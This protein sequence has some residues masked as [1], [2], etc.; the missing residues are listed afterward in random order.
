MIGIIPAAGHSTRIYG[1]PKFLLPIANSYLL[2]QLTAHMHGANV[3][4]I[5]LGTHPKHYQLFSD[6]MNDHDWHVYPYW[7][8]TTTMNETVLAARGRAG[9][10]DIL[11]GM[12]DTYWTDEGVY[13]RLAQTLNDEVGVIASVALWYTPE[14]YR[15][16]RGMCALDASGNLITGVLDK[17]EKTGKTFG[18]GAMA[19]S[20]TF[21]QYILPEDAHVGF[22]LQRAIDDDQ[23]VQGVVMDG[24]FWDCGTPDEYFDCIRALEPVKA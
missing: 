3:D 8:D 18:W 11:F 19:W 6:L 10:H 22:A 20:S 13:Q 21:W 23:K 5:L 14:Q 17:P 24:Q 12:P 1:L 15:H 9:N 4:H 2:D 16:K 7:C